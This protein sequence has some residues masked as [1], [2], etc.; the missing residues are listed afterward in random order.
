MIRDNA[1][2]PKE[3]VPLPLSALIL[4]G[5]AGRRMGGLD[6]GWQRHRRQPLI[7]HA[8]DTVQDRAQEVFISANRSLDAYG[9]LGYPVLVDAEPGFAGPLQGIRAGFAAMQTDWLACIPVDCPDLPRD[10]LDR[11]WRSRGTEPLVVAGDAHGITP[12]VA[13]MHRS[14]SDSLATYLET[15]DAS[16][17]GWMRKIPQ[18]LLPLDAAALRNINRPEDLE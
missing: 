16:V 4:A 18:R 15:G 12:V 10:L 1:R 3:S 11:L 9:R 7:A 2:M 13:L 6:K 5:G 8:L 14:L 17:R